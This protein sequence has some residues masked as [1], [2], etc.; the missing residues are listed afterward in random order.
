MVE[1][2]RG[3]AYLVPLTDAVLLALL[4]HALVV[5]DAVYAVVETASALL[6]GARE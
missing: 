4:E 6:A 5:W 2:R 1:I 3:E